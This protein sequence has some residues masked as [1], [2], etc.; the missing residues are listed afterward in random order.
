MP[1]VR[2]YRSLRIQRLADLAA[3]SGTL[4]LILSGRFG[5]V[6]SQ[7]L[8]PYYDHLL[9]AEEVS[10]MVGTVAEQIKQK[11]ISHVT[12]F[13]KSTQSR[14]QLRPYT[15]LIERACSQATVPFDLRILEDAEMPNWREIMKQAENAKRMLIGDRAKGEE[16]FEALLE[17][18]DGDGMVYFKR[19]EAWEAIGELR[20]ALSDY[21]KAVVLF[22]M[23]K[24]KELAREAC[25]RVE[26]QLAK[27][28]VSPPLPDLSGTDPSLAE[29][30]RDALDSL[31]K[32]PRSVMVQCRVALE[33]VIEYL[34]KKNEVHSDRSTGLAEKIST[35]K[36]SKFISAT[37]A[38]HMHT[39]R[40]LGNEAAH[41]GPVSRED[42]EICGAALRAVLGAVF[43]D[44]RKSK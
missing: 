10:G 32:E 17:R 20:L 12:F 44:R 6:E 28:P 23:P 25:K 24:F 41:G 13:S 26:D 7:E 43:N 39:V 18:Y 19:G 30:C 40:V 42:A 1:A 11:G 35:L 34:I 31:N 29:V 27:Q 15:E 8:V 37:I 16:A 22:P 38:S 3:R 2:R 21:R 14:P 33:K 5:L 4:F 9:Q 36:D